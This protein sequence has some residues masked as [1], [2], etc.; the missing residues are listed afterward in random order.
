[1][2]AQNIWF[3]KP[4]FTVRVNGSSVNI[5]EMP[6]NISKPKTPITL[7]SGNTYEWKSVKMMSGEYGWYYKGEV[8]YN[9]K[10][11]MSFKEKRRVTTT[12]TKSNLPDNDLSLLL[13]IGTY[14]MFSIQQG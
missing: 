10:F 14:F 8:I 3:L 12:F 4:E 1:M 13:L 9:F 11:V 5:I 2:V 7:P 6:I